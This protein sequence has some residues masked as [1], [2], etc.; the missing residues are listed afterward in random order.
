MDSNNIRAKF[1]VVKDNH[2]L[3][4]DGILGNDIRSY[5]GA[6]INLRSSELNL[7]PFKNP[8]KIICNTK[9]E[10]TQIFFVEPRS[11]TVS[12]V[13]ILKKIFLKGFAP[14]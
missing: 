2:N 1:H 6:T 11:E 4:H 9:I 7:K 10:K 3:P 8:K 5:Y 12:Q 13:D 14:N